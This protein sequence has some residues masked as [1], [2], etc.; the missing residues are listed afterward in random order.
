MPLDVVGLPMGRVLV[1]GARPAA[2]GVSYQRSIKRPMGVHR[3]A[4]T[5]DQRQD[6]HYKVVR[7]SLND[8]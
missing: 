5:Y 7:V 6:F 4:T 2:W 3:P 1:L 8:E